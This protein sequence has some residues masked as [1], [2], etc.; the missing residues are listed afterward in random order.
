[1]IQFENE[2]CQYL[3]LPS[4]PLKEWDGKSSFKHGVAVTRLALNE[5][6]Y[7]VCTF[8]ADKDKEPR[9]VR[10]FAQ[11]TFYGIEK[12]FVVPQFMNTDVETMDLDDESKIAAEKLAAEVKEMT[13]P[14]DEEE[15]EINAMNALPEWIFPEIENKEQAVAWLRQYNSRNRIKG[16]IPENADTLKMRLLNI[17]SQQKKK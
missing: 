14:Q 6:A 17:Y 16:R 3:S 5:K 12:I 13:K 2:I 15:K 10:A 9:V 4:I 11:S 1:M 7:A 8:D